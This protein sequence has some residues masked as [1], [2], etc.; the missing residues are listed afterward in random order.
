M[1][2]LSQGDYAG[3]HT[4]LEGLEAGAAGPKGWKVEDD[5]FIQYPIRLESWLM[6]GSYD[7]VWG[8]TKSERVPCEEFAIFSDVGHT[9]IN[10]QI[11]I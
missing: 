7:R 8:E 3:F 4:L 9:I 1:L 6:E 5:E 2:L 11:T 10:H